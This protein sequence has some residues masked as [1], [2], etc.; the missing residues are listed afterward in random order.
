MPGSTRMRIVAGRWGSRKLEAPP[1][2]EHRPTAERVREAI[3]SRLGDR[4]TG[5]VVVDLFAGSGALGLEALSR[6]ARQATFV[7]RA[8]AALEALRR[9]V[10]AL[11][12]GDCSRIVVADVSGFLAG[13]HGTQEGVTLLL[14]DPPYGGDAAI[15]AERL[16]DAAGIVWGRGALSVIECGSRDADW[17]PAAG[18]R[19]WPGRKYGDTRIVI[20]ERTCQDAD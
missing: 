14:A 9:N 12:A 8:P 11:E 17:P 15:F 5:A 1:G 20:D 3:F 6:G 13:Q 16:P 19:R 4:V 7:E 2:R 10:A 18:W